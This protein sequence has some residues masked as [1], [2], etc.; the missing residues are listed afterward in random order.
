[1]KGYQ[2]ST[3]MRSTISAVQTRGS[4]A[5]ALSLWPRPNIRQ[6]PLG[7]DKLW[8]KDAIRTRVA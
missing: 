2:N 6:T 7:L 5:D 8:E 3:L 1:M 4:S